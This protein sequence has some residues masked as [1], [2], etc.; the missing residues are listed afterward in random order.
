MGSIKVKQHD[1]R[2]CGPACLSSVGS[3][4]GFHLPIA[5]IRQW[6]GTDQ[7][8]TNVL[9][10]LEAA[11]KMGLRARGVRTGSDSLSVIP[12]PAIAHVVQKPAQRHHYVV[13]YKVNEKNILLM[14]PSKGRLKKCSKNEFT[15]SWT[16]VLVLFA[17]K[18]NFRAIN[19]KKSNRLR[20]W[21]LVKPQ[22]GV[23]LKALIAALLFTIL[24]L[25]ISIYVQQIADQVLGTDNTELLSFLSLCMFLILGLQA[26]FGCIKRI[27]VIKSGHNI[28]A[29]LILGYYRHLL[30]LPQRFFD[31]MQ[32]GEIISRVNDAI[33]IR[34]F[35]NNI[36]IEMLVNCLI[37]I[38]ALIVMFVYYWRLAVIATL[39]IPLYLVVYLVVNKFNTKVERR[40]M[41][42]TAEL[43]SWL[44]ESISQ[45]KTMKQFGMEVYAN[46]RL[47]KKLKPLLS[48]SFKSGLNETFGTSS[49][50]F[51]ASF[52]TVLLLWL[53]SVNVMEGNITT[54]E[55]FSFYALMGYFSGPVSAL[56]SMNKSIQN[57]LIAADRLFEIMD[58]ERERPGNNTTLKNVI[59]GD[60]FYEN[61]NFRYGTRT[62]VFRDFSLKI[63]RNEITAIVGESG[64]GK[65]TL[66]SLL[67]GLY[68]LNSGRIRIGQLDI[69][70][71]DRRS[72]HSIIGVI[73]QQIHLFSGNIIENIALG[74]S[75]PDLSR[76]V[77]LSDQL[78]IRTFV[79]QLPSGF[80]T[81]L[82]ENG[83]FLS[84]GQKQR[85]AIARALYSDPEML[86][87]DEATA[88][89]DSRSRKQINRV[90]T[91]LKEQKKTIIIIAHRLRT[92]TFADRIIVLDHGQVVEE[93]NHRQLIENRGY[94]YTMWQSEIRS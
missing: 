94:Y 80:E 69:Q 77:Q 29:K 9:G 35:I 6:A 25:G 23:L 78:G 20:F 66:I 46:K 44:V 18:E 8:G 1:S 34:A 88:S 15:N 27:Y 39:I 4:F 2:D 72:L 84:G 54:G 31:T 40:L 50:H 89:L 83:A 76:I 86:L 51:L 53:G 75:V 48:S 62:E 42:Q 45:V 49:T 79:E 56:V 73:P 70:S 68:P 82:G 3:Y 47:E 60:I 65:T 30:Q 28:D 16:G 13:L 87:M 7:M 12:M 92:I 5:R 81:Q 41:E 90:I 55:L 43:E 64:C 21:H 85:I 67:Q 17:R 26:F 32:V 19:K 14:D 71:T 10:L 22:G 74:D 61:I 33:K 38:S 36:A 93:G 63:K 52:F 24:G 57:A 91:E 11:D 58:L 59:S 37:V